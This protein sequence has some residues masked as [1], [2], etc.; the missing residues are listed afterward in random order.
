MRIR[1]S[2]R[3][4]IRDEGGNVLALG[5]AMMP[6]MIGTAA[7][8]LDTIQMSLWKRQLQRAADSAALAGAYAMVQGKD[9]P[10]AVARDLQLNNDVALHGPARVEN[11]PESGSYAGNPL[12]VRVVLTSQRIMPFMAFFDQTPATIAAEATAAR[13]YQGQHCMVSLEETAVTGITFTGNTNLT[14]GCGIATNSKAASSIIA[15]GSARIVATPVSGVGG[16][17]AS[18][19]YVPPTKL[20]P[21]SLKQ[22]DP[23][24]GLP[25]QP[26]PPFICQAGLD[27]QPNRILSVE[28][29]G[30]FKGMKIQGTLNLAPGTYYIDGSGGSGLEL[31]ATA[32]VNGTGVTI[33]LTS[34]T[35]TVPSSFATLSMHANAIVNLS[36]PT[37]GQ[38]KGILFY[39][40]PRTPYAETVVNG[41]SASVLE[42]GFYFPTHQ[43]RFNGNTGLQTKCMQMVAL[44][45]VFSGNS[46]VQNDCPT[47]GGG[48]AFDSSFVRL[49]A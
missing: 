42:G 13:V 18:G 5:A 6:F 8:A 29:E 34:S 7:L 9:H 39:Q 20:L 4:L 21:Y 2:I 49:V 47:S 23:Y 45:L 33:V 17:P 3:R 30:C 43:L 37:S 32:R 48:R 16:V 14:L 11:A 44:R 31:G 35:P 36:S 10:A 1:G 26:S 46:N 38:Y 24:A 19:A 40:D 22:P 25:R 27:L 12:A 41:N 15:D 28:T